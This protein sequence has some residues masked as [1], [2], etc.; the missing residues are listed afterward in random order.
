MIKLVVGSVGRSA[1]GGVDPFCSVMIWPDLS[2]DSLVE[3]KSFRSALYLK[4][5][6]TN[7]NG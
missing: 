7:L 5:H 3:T 4:I 2:G 6:L 1:T